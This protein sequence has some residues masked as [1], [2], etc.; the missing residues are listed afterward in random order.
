M[1]I[2]TVII[3]THRHGTTEHEHNKTFFREVNKVW[4]YLSKHWICATIRLL[5]GEYAPAKEKKNRK[6]EKMK[7]SFMEH[8]RLDQ[9]EEDE[10]LRLCDTLN[11]TKSEVFR[12]LLKYK[13]VYGKPP[14]E[15]GKL[16]AE[17]RRVGVNLNQ[18]ARAINAKGFINSSE[19][20]K[21][22]DDLYVL[23]HKLNESVCAKCE[24]LF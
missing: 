5:P 17:I 8:V 3:V 18:I 7:R 6:G 4:S 15:F 2:K 22:L 12:R 19:L 11:C 20:R 10:L 24:V 23:E 21:A 16:I 1:R 13:I 14:L 9:S